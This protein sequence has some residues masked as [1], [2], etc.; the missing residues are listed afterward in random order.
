MSTNR[1][2]K[3]IAVAG[4]KGGAGKTVFACMLGACLAGF[5][6]RTVLVDLDFAGANVG[7]YLNSPRSGKNLNAYFAGRST[8]LTDVIRRTS[9]ENLDAIT[10]QSESFSSQ[11]C[12]PWQKRRLFQDLS[13]LK[14]DYIILDLGA[15]SSHVGLDAFMMADHGI[16][17]S[18]N[19]MFSIINTYSFIRSALLRSIKRRFY[20][21]PHVLRMLDE[22]GL[23]VDGKCIK[24]L[25]AVIHQFDETTQRKFK[26]LENL[27]QNFHPKVVLN[28]ADES[29]KMDD[30]FLLGPVAKDLLHVDLDY[31]GHVRFDDR[32][33][34]AIHSHRPEHLLSVNGKA[35][36]DLVRLVVRNVISAEFT[37]TKR[38]SHWFQKDV[39]VFNLFNETDSLPCTANCVLWN[40]C[41]TRTEGG[42]CTKM[43]A[44]LLKRA[45]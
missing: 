45:G 18:T 30:F 24:P 3:I 6:R 8:S 16:L 13:Q 1:N 4:G 44:D 12:K 34:Q 17:L 22:C 27:W 40:G 25:H 28:F 38:K 31:W 10:L 9:F 33:S 35:S 19:D 2:P 39:N 26:G 5:D 41:P 14:A 20:D 42:L 32:V 23:L 29:E 36:E 43:N 21:S 7:Q 15:A 11:S 37:P